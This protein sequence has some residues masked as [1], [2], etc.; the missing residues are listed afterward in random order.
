MPTTEETKYQALESCPV[1]SP[2]AQTSIEPQDGN[3]RS[4]PRASGWSQQI[5]SRRPRLCRSTALFALLCSTTVLLRIGFSGVGNSLR[6]F[7]HGAASQR[8]GPGTGSAGAMRAAGLVQQVGAA[9]R[10]LE[11]WPASRTVTSRICG[12]R[13]L[14]CVARGPK[15]RRGWHL[16]KDARQMWLF[17]AKRLQPADLLVTPSAPK[18]KDIIATPFRL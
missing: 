1:V 6:D 4:Q 15:R 7:G 12:I 14:A 3:E 17:V 13:A 9:A 10:C 2:S 16:L 11:V 5:R 8:R 18:S